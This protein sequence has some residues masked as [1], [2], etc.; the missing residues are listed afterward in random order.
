MIKIIDHPL[1]ISAPL[2]PATLAGIKVMTR[3][4]GTVYDSWKVGEGIWIKEN[5]SAMAIFD[6]LP[7]SKLLDVGAIWY[8]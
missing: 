1:I 8:C 7:P 6:D 3:R 4:I 5:Y 2:I